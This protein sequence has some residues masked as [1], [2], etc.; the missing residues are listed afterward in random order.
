MKH[1][2]RFNPQFQIV[3]NRQSNTTDFDDTDFE[4][5]ESDTE[6]PRMSMGSVCYT[7][8]PSLQTNELT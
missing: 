5:S 2:A 7:F 3:Q 6:S 4:F 8:P 1:T